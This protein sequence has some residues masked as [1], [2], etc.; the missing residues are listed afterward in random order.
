[1]SK[2]SCSKIDG[3]KGKP[4]ANAVRNPPVRSAD[5]ILADCSVVDWSA[6]FVSFG[7]G[8]G[9]AYFRFDGARSRGSDFAPVG[10]VIACG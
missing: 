10:A 3:N 9:G 5:T 8:S 7:A 4:L 6:D 2:G 1:M